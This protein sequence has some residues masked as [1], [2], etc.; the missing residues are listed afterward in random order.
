MQGGG[1]GFATYSY[2]GKRGNG[3]NHITPSKIQG[4]GV[5]MGRTALIVLTNNEPRDMPTELLERELQQILAENGRIR[6]KWS[7]EKVTILDES[8]HQSE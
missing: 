8:G 6:G 5:N 4:L 2:A 3:T 7:V 1:R